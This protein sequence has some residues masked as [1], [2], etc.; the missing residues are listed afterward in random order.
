M[1]KDPLIKVDNVKKYFGSTKAVDGISLQIE[2]GEFVA[3]LGPNGAGKTTLVEMIEGIQKPD[4]GEISIKGLLWGKNDKE[5]REVIGLSLQETHF[6]DKLR[7][8]ETLA[9]F[10][11]FYSLPKSRIETALEMVGLEV[12]R[13]TYTKNLSGGQKQKLALGIAFLNQPEILLLD[14]P[15][16]GLDPSARR[17]VW[18]ILMN[19]KR[20]FNTAMILTT[21]YM[22]EASYLCKR[23]IMVDKGKVLARGTLEQLLAEYKNG[24]IINFEVDSGID[25]KVFKELGHYLSINLQEN[26]KKGEIIVESLVNYMPALLKYIEQKSLK[27]SAIECRK[28]TLDD[29]FITLTGRHLTE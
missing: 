23:I 3:L 6:I 24:E 21:H 13:K 16:T 19:M 9:L 15:T 1:Q 4:K 18:D 5:I 12:K 17:E 7:V 29:L 14:E 25:E 20:E 2:K 22:E 11:S 28:M 10:A 27:L 26:N 8:D